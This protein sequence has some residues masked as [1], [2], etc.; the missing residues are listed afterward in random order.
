MMRLLEFQKKVEVL[1][2]YLAGVLLIIL[3]LL[4][5]TEVIM[6]KFLN[7]S[8]PGVF[9]ISSQLMVGVTVLGVSYVQFEKEHIKVDIFG[10]RLPKWTIILTDIL[11]SILGAVLTGIFGYQGLL[12]FIESF[13]LG[14]TA[15]GII[16][17]PFW[18]GRLA[19]LLAMFLLCIRFIIELINLCTLKSTKL[20]LLNEGKSR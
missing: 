13:K 1:L 18:P 17:V 20:E 9:E 3:M 7:Y 6:R 4:V 19:I 2:V 8:I 5:T 16:S 15:M 10:K 14:E 11:T 12:K